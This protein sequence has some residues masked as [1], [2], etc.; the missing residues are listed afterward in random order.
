MGEH[1]DEEEDEDL[2]KDLDEDLADD[3][4]VSFRHFSRR[5]SFV[6]GILRSVV[7]NTIHKREQR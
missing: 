2:D 4:C 6:D 5:R 3:L 7:A 1:A